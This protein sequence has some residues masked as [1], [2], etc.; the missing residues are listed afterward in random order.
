MCLPYYHRVAFVTVIWVIAGLDMLQV[1][2]REALVGG[3]VT[4]L[5]YKA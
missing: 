5:G 3:D 1:K 2:G 4:G